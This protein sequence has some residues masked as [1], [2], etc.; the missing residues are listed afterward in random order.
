MRK[1]GRERGS[2]VIHSRQQK[3]RGY[4]SL[5]AKKLKLTLTR[6]SESLSDDVQGESIL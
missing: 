3:Q 2:D 4:L 6:C 5:V 1:L